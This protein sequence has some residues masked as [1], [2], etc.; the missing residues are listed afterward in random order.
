MEHNGPSLVDRSSTDLTN[1]ELW[2]LRQIASGCTIEKAARD[3]EPPMPRNTA[4]SRLKSAYRKLN[5]ST[6]PSAVIRAIQLELISAEEIRCI[7]RI[8]RAS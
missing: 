1:N 8:K 3:A 6:G 2:L 5:V 7:P 4:L